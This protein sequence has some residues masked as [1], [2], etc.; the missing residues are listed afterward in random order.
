LIP[1]TAEYLDGPILLHAPVE[2]PAFAVASVA[3]GLQA[4][5]PTDG[6]NAAKRFLEDLIYRGQLDPGPATGMMAALS[7]AGTPREN[8]THKL[9]RTEKGL[10]LKRVQFDCCCH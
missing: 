4:S 5:G 10:V 1:L 9:E 3:R 8:R 2:P 6:A 7:A